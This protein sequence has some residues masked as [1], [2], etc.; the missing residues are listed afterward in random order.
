MKGLIVYKSKYGSTR[1]YAQWISEELNF[2]IADIKGFDAGLLESYD[3]VIIGSHIIGGKIMIAE[4]IATHEQLLQGKPLYFFTVSGTPPQNK[5]LFELYKESVSDSLQKRAQ[6]FAFHGKMRYDELDRID[7]VTMN[8]GVL[9]SRKSA[10]RD[11]MRKGY[12]HVKKK[13]IFGLVNAV[14]KNMK[15]V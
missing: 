6:F 8:M 13:A 12:D 5:S 10:D 2:D 3:V 15:N 4:W 1:Q 9:M 7:K 11:A 14:K